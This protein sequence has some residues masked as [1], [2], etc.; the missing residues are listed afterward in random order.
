VPDSFSTGYKYNFT[1]ELVANSYEHLA[2]FPT[3]LEITH[4]LAVAESLARKISM[5]A[6]IDPTFFA[7]PPLPSPNETPSDDE[8]SNEGKY[9]FD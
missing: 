9:I 1:N 2:H 3:N 5:F 4:K 6:G 8:D 7:A